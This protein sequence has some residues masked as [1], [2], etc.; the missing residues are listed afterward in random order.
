MTRKIFNFD[1]LAESKLVTD[2]ADKTQIYT[3]SI[4]ACGCLFYKRGANSEIELLLIAYA[5]PNWPRLDDLGGK[6]DLTDETVDAAIAREVSE[7]S[8]RMI[9]VDYIAH[10]H[11]IPTFYNHQAKYVVKCIEVNNEFFP[12]TDLFGTV[13]THDNIERTIKWYKYTEIKTKLAY[14]LYYNKNLIEYLD[15]L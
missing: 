7:E 3:N 10:V 8:N 2:L 12:D 6:I 13:E 14:R 15:N 9:E 11:D 4:S 1:N 5:D